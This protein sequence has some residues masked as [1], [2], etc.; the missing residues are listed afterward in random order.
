MAGG[1]QRAE[2]DTRFWDTIMFI[3][4]RVDMLGRAM[5]RDRQLPRPPK[6]ALLFPELSENPWDTG[7]ANGAER[8]F[9]GG[10][11]TLELCAG[12]GGQALGIEQA[13]VEHIALVELNK[14]ACMTPCLIAPPG[15]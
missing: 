1:E 13:G 8:P 9:S 4:P 5:I 3:L 14:N 15:M 6:T 2:S 7:T 10:P 12:A 11:T